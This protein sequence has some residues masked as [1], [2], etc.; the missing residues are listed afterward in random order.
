MLRSRV[1]Y[2]VLLS[3]VLAISIGDWALGAWAES[4][5]CKWTKSDLSRK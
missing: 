1:C 5:S 4:G 3:F 2:R